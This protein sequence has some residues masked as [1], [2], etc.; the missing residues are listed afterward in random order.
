MGVLYQ[1][2]FSSFGNSEQKKQKQ[3]IVATR[4]VPPS[5]RSACHVSVLTYYPIMGQKIS[6]LPWH[7]E[8]TSPHFLTSSTLATL[9]MFRQKQM[10]TNNDSAQC[11]EYIY[12]SKIVKLENMW[13][14][15]KIDMEGDV[16]S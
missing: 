8:K 13:T 7:Q 14:A 10:G 1:L 12:F 5:P 16:F 6:S 4:S 15:T 3:N 2:A 11:A 9:C